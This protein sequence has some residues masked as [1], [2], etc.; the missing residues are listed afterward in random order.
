MGY[1]LPAA[2]GACFAH[3]RKQ[4][5]CIAGDGSIQMNIQELQTIV[6]HN[7]PIKIFLLNNNGYTSIRLTQDAYFPGGYVAADPSSGVTFPDIQKICAAYGIQS[8]QVKNHDELL[9]KILQ[10]LAIPGPALCEIMM[11]PDQPLFPKLASE[12]RPDGTMVSKPL[13]DMYPFLDREEFLENML[14]E[15]WNNNK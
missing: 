14:I 15:P 9:E 12:V 2:I 1:D 7:L 6:H 13:E 3:N 5:I 8:N 10:I 11:A 4:I